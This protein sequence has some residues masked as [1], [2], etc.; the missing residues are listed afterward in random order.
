M[1][2]IGSTEFIVRR[3]K[4]KAVGIENLNSL[5]EAF[6]STCKREIEVLGSKT[7]PTNNELRQSYENAWETNGLDL[8][9]R[10][11]ESASGFKY[12]HL[13]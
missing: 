5:C 8:V 10:F 2:F 6:G 12:S 4:T 3:I 9:K 1:V 13:F 7:R 11:L